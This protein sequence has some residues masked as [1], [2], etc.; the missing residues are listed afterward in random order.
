[1][2]PNFLDLF[3]WS[4]PFVAEKV[5]EMLYHV[6]KPDQKIDENEIVPI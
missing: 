1:L 2:L 5:T 4:I 6:I 3:S